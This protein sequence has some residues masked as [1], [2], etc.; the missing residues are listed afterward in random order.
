MYQNFVLWAIP[1]HL[2][3]IYEVQYYKNNH[4][5]LSILQI[6]NKVAVLTGWL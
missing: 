2:I 6:N 3:S 1:S 5:T 4:P